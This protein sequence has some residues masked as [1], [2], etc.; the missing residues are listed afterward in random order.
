MGS[1]GIADIRAF[2]SPAP[3]DGDADVGTVLS[4]VMAPVTDP[5]ATDPEG[6]ILNFTQCVTYL[7][8]PYLN[9]GSYPDWTTR[10][11]IA[12]TTGD[13]EV[14]GL[15]GGAVEQSGSVVLHAFP[16]SIPTADGAS[17]LVPEAKVMEVTSSLA[18]GDTV[19]FN[20]NEGMLARFEGYAIARTGFRH[21]HGMAMILINFMQGHPWT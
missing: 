13:D 2:L 20:C 5:E 9:C 11:A 4:Y 10:I 14:F 3:A 16:R 17:G 12:N 15:G 21:A 1:G 7:L 19:S 18:A 8:F 6:R